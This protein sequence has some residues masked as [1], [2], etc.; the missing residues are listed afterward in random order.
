MFEMYHT[1]MCA[2]MCVT[3][4]YLYIY[5]SLIKWFWLIILVGSR[6][7]DGVRDMIVISDIDENGINTNLHVRYKEDIIYVSFLWLFDKFYHNS[8]QKMYI[9]W[10]YS[11]STYIVSSLLSSFSLFLPSLLHN[12][13]GDFASIFQ[14]YF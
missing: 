13:M 10:L 11:A 4:V 7:E 2:Y 12:M 6:P 8:L 3:C 14:F 5:I 9:H 1:K